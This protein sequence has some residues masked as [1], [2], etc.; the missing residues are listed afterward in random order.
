[1][2]TGCEVAKPVKY[3]GVYVTGKNVELFKN[4]YERLWDKIKT[5]LQVWNKFGLSLMGCIAMIKM[6]VLPKLMFLFQA[7]PII[8][9]LK[10]LEK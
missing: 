9:N 2:L 6:Q 4:N 7:I 5:D 8:S 10:I 3:L 1:M